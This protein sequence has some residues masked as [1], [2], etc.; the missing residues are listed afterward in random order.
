MRKALMIAFGLV[1]AWPLVYGFVFVGYALGVGVWNRDGSHSD[2]GEE[3]P[4]LNAIITLHVITMFWECVLIALYIYNVFKNDRVHKDKKALWAVVLFLG[5][6][7]AMP[8]YWYLYIW[9]QDSRALTTV[10][11]AA[12]DLAGCARP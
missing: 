4:G 10:N 1:T 8:I 2:T 6:I 9:R 3:S 5:N 12:T 7:V 11:A